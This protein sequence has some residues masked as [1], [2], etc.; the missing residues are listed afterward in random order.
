MLEFLGPP[1]PRAASDAFVAKAEACFD[2][3]GFGHWAVE[4]PGVAS[5]IGFIGLE[6]VSFDAPFTPAV[7]IGWRLDS[8]HWGNG[9]AT[10]GAR[11]ALDYA[12]GTVGLLEVV[13]FTAQ[14]N[15]RSRR[16]M[17][18]IGM[19]HDPGGGFEHPRVPEGDPL[20]SH[21]LYRVRPSD[22]RPAARR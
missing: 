8:R 20:R 7:E 22:P 1:R 17:E 16:V 4:V 12:F 2:E 13:S 5:C 18:R 19:R 21:V 15:V 10:E 11:A 6:P 3:H 9:Y 14:G